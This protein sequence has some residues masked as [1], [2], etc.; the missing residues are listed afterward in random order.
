VLVGVATREL[1]QGLPAVAREVRAWRRRARAI[2]D[3]SIRHDALSALARKRGHTD[4]AALFWTLPA[5]DSRDLLRLLVA[6]EITWDFLDSVNERGA[7]AGQRNGRQLHLALLE[8]L[9]PGVPI[10]DYYRHHPWREDGGY[11]STLV[12][13]CRAGCVR[14]PSYDRA[15]PLLVQEAARAQVLAINHD[16]DPVRR[17]GSLRAWAEHEFPAGHEATWFELTGAASASLTIHVLLALAAEAACAEV[18]LVRAQRAYFP[19][20]SAATTMLDS[21]V[22]QLEDAANGDHSY[23]AHYPTP[24]S[25]LPPIRTLLARSFGEA[26][27]L[28]DAEHHILIVACMVAMYLSKNS[29]R[30]RP[31]RAGTESLVCAG[32]SLTRVL[33][34]ILRLWRVLYAQRST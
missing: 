2:P 24:A 12:E 1:L 33:L 17:D 16:L 13:V 34:P 29:A 4:G 26:R 31:L 7:A 20:I 21:F 6:Y 14:L 9:D 19:W 25:A 10:S 18:D 8:A 11:L 15:R 27:A 22:D 5:V 32:G 28:A 30:S 3:A 23:V